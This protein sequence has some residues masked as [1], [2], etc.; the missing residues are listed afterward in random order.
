MKFV[1]DR[2]GLEYGPCD[3]RFPGRPE[4]CLHD[5]P[6]DDGEAGIASV[7]RRER[8]RLDFEAHERGP[9]AVV[10]AAFERGGALQP[11]DRF[12][13]A[14]NFRD[15][16]YGLQAEKRLRLRDIGPSLRAGAP[17]AFRA[18]A[19]YV[20]P[21]GVDNW[22][23]CRRLHPNRRFAGTPG[24]FVRTIL[25]AAR[26]ADDDSGNALL[27]LAKGTA[28]APPDEVPAGD[29]GRVAKTVARVLSL[30][31]RP[32]D[33][34]RPL[35]DYFR[36][37]DE[38]R[39]VPAGEGDATAFLPHPGY[40]ARDHLAIPAVP[41][42]RRS[43][44][45]RAVL[46][47]EAR[48]GDGPD[49]FEAAVRAGKAAK[50]EADRRRHF[51]L[52]V[53]AIGTEIRPVGV[54]THSLTLSKTPLGPLAE[55]PSA[56]GFRAGWQRAALAGPGGPRPAA[57]C[58]A[59]PAD[60]DPVDPADP[61][62]P[63]ASVRVLD[64]RF[65]LAPEPGAWAAERAFA[66][67]EARERT[68]P[69]AVSR[70]GGETNLAGIVERALAAD[71]R[72]GALV[73]ALGARYAALSAALDAWRAAAFAGTEDALAQVGARLEA[74]GPDPAPVRKDRYPHP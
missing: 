36:E 60:A 51:A 74:S 71:A 8:A 53:A 17:R 24:A 7:S 63:D 40:A 18:I 41:L 33:A 22:A 65:L 49:E 54:F 4:T 55:R 6:E 11:E 28:F 73:S 59:D 29:R 52:G 3:W 43:L 9:A 12:A 23:Q 10:A 38:Y 47:V 16:V 72:D 69:M 46:L 26:L 57:W 5:L 56:D 30:L 44:G 34:L 64:L 68:V 58:V 39:L 50:F 21:L 20:A 61:E 37:V 70:L 42:A 62:A 27:A 45:R 32:L 35:D 67:P 25:A 13:L 66:P 15:Y 31:R 1:A 2:Y 14:R 48:D 19:E